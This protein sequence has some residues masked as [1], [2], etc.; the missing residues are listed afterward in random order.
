MAQAK[1]MRIPRLDSFEA[2]NE[3]HDLLITIP[4]LN[5]LPTELIVR[6]FVMTQNPDLRLVNRRFHEISSSNLLRAHYIYWHYGPSEAMSAEAVRCPLFSR[7]VAEILLSFDCDLIPIEE[8]IVDWAIQHGYI[9]LCETIFRIMQSRNI[10]PL[11]YYSIK[12][13]EE[14][15]IAVFELLMSMF[16][17]PGSFAQEAILKCA[18]VV[19]RIDFVRHVIEPPYNFDHRFKDEY[20]L[21]QAAYSGYFELVQLFISHGSD[22]H[23]RGEGA[24][25]DATHR[26]HYQITQLLLN[27]GAD[28]HVNEDCAL[29]FSAAK[30]HAD[31]V[32]LLL[33]HG[34]YATAQ[35]SKALRQASKSGY[36]DVVKLLLDSGADPNAGMGAPLAGAALNG[37]LDVVQLLLAH[38]ANIDSR[39]GSRAVQLAIRDGHV[40]VVRELVKAGADLES[41]ETVKLLQRRGREDVLKAVEELGWQNPAGTSRPVREVS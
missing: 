15:S 8:G 5:N 34:A 7:S 6:I 35:H 3:S 17:T 13:A 24:L 10:P 16:N 32:K 1:P 29:R 14:G 37:H 33:D 41:E 40:D 39:G 28:L 23:C 30:G 31:V 38:G 12:A 25:M 22:I 21:R 26:G 9:N 27:N 18:S 20:L 2:N 11:D 36:K 19:N 4:S